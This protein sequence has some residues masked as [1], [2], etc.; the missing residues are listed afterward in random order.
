MGNPFFSTVEIL[1][2]VTALSV[3]AFVASFAYGTNR[4]KIPL[5]SVAVISIICSAIFAVSLFLGSLIR[6]FMP[7]HFA[8]LLCFAILFVLGI[9][10]LCDSAIKSFIR[11]SQGGHKKISFSAMHLRFILDVYANPENA[12]SDCSKSLSPKEAAPLAIAL[13][14]DGLAVGFGAALPDVNPIQ[15]ILFSL[16]INVA[17]V[18]LGC[19]VGNKVAEKVPLDLSWVSGLLLMVLAFLKLT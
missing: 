5:R 13:S 11:R 1:V 3:D 8:G 14:L 2:L 18:C 19:L 17:A 16:I 12:D 15:A 9:V 4:I 6:P 10:K 7:T